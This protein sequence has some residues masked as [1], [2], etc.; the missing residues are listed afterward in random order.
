MYGDARF[1]MTKLSIAIFVAALT[2]SCGP[3]NTSLSNDDEMYDVGYD[4]GYATGYNTTCEIRA[5][6]INDYD[7]RF[8]REGYDDGYSAG[9][10]ECHSSKR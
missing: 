3:N 1:F 10:K 5:T 9:A 8:Y 4:D 6:L 2:A 7:D